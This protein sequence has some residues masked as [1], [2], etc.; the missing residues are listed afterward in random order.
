VSL[1]G[2]TEDA[3]RLHSAVLKRQRLSSR[4][5]QRFLATGSPWKASHDDVRQ[6][7]PDI[8]ICQC[9]GVTRGQLTCA[10]AA[11]CE[12]VAALT[13]ETGAGSVCGSCRPLLARLTGATSTLAVRFVRV[14]IASCVAVTL[15]ALAHLLFNPIPLATS[16]RGRG[17][18][19]LW[20]DGTLKQITGY[21]LLGLMLLGLALPLRKRLHALAKVGD[22][23]FWRVLHTGLGAVALLA[24]V[25]HT[26]FRLGFQLN[27]VL[28]LNVL[29]LALT[30]ALSGGVT[31]LT[32]RLPP[33]GARLLQTGW[34]CVHAFLCWPLL[35]LIVFHILTVYRY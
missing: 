23:A 16:I 33:R 29:A 7:A 32:H 2:N 19:N 30:G 31:A 12:T 8:A 21:L 3:G 4:A 14:L 1:L 34:T 28:M 17:I 9:T 27:Q 26:G 11:G 10:M 18:D 25:S 13:A 15:V 24:L 5:Q 35:V 6:W 22:Y 20:L